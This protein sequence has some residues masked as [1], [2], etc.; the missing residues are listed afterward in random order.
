LISNP[1]L[2]LEASAQSRIDGFCSRCPPMLCDEWC[3]IS[4]GLCTLKLDHFFMADP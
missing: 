4:V 2:V 1:L 3:V